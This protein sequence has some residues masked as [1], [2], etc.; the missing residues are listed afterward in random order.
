MKVMSKMAIA[1]ALAVA[2]A[3]VVAQSE[4][5]DKGKDDAAYVKVEIKGTL[6][7]GV[8]AIGGESTGY[9][10]TANTM[11]FELDF[12]KNKEFRELADK[13]NGKTVVVMGTLNMR[14]GVEIKSRTIV[15]V[16]GIK[17]E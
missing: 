7:T 15:T 2:C 17:A 8:M 5:G 6:Q 10:L 3:A 11:R 9:V 16:T 1:L 12:G 13:S 14:K 4:A